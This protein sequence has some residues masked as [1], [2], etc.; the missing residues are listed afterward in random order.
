M[1][2]TKHVIFFMEAKFSE[3]GFV[4][5]SSLVKAGYG[6]HHSVLC[7]LK[8]LVENG[9]VTLSKSD[10]GENRFSVTEENEKKFLREPYIA[11]M[12]RL[13]G[14]YKNG[15]ESLNIGA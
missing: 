13:V 12:L 15:V 3:G 10:Y 7:T 6:K 11:D 9:Y 4:T 1:A 8:Q 2:G 14:R 5:A